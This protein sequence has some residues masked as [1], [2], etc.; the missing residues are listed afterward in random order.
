MAGSGI[1]R[2]TRRFTCLL[3]I[4]NGCLASITVYH[5]HGWQV[6][7]VPTS[8]G[9][10]ALANY[11]GPAAYNP[12]RLIPPTPPGSD[13]LAVQFGIQFSNVVPSGASIQQSGS[14]MGFSVEMSVADQVCEHFFDHLSLFS[15]ISIPSQK[16]EKTRMSH[17]ISAFQ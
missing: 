8:S 13:A 17:Y 5:Q 7:L 3:A 1:L 11:T 2:R 12:T 10:A 16:S 9:M 14:F 6:P 4:I 15:E